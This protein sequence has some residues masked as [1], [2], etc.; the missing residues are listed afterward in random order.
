MTLYHCKDV[1]NK[2]DSHGHPLRDDLSVSGTWPI[3]HVSLPNKP[4]S[5]SKIRRPRP[6]GHWVGILGLQIR[7]ASRACSQL[8]NPTLCVKWAGATCTG[9]H[10]H[11]L[12][13]FLQENG[14]RVPNW[15]YKLFF[16]TEPT[17]EPGDFACFS[18]LPFKVLF[19]SIY[20]SIL[21]PLETKTFS[22]TW[23]S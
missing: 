15:F 3:P 1:C 13:L 23:K 9:A 21:D 14:T 18:F 11:F 20:T 22:S 17:T 5:L 16:G 19:W 8:H 7:A 6:H 2:A 4:C 12:P 10:P